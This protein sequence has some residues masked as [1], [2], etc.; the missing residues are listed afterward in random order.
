MTVGRL[1]EIF[2][3]TETR[4]EGSGSCRD[5][6]IP[7][8]QWDGAMWRTVWPSSSDCVRSLLASARANALCMTSVVRRHSATAQST[9]PSSRSV[10]ATSCLLGVAYLVT[11]CLTLDSVLAESQLK[12]EKLFVPELCE[13]KSKKGDQLT[14][15]YTGTLVDGTKFDSRSVY[16]MKIKKMKKGR[17]EH[18]EDTDSLCYVFLRATNLKHFFSSHQNVRCQKFRWKLMTWVKRG[19][20]N[21]RWPW[22]RG[23]HADTIWISDT[24]RP[25]YNWICSEYVAVNGNFFSLLFRDR[26]D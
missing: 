8:G 20:R 10:R 3:R 16:Q 24:L 7:R 19:F 23:F 9:M 22:E 5:L 2:R 1:Y 13:Q 6:H 4:K 26:Q 15:H 17:V 21:S 14:M 11:W 18:I 25:S 12:V